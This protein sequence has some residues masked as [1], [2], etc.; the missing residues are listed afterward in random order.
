MQFLEPQLKP[1]STAD[2]IAL[3]DKDFD[4]NIHSREINND[5]EEEV[6]PKAKRK[7]FAKKMEKERS[8]YLKALPMRLQHQKHRKVKHLPLLLCM[9][10][11]NCSKWMLAPVQSPRKGLWTFFSKMK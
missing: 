5:N 9:L 1:E 8:N 6:A 7:S 11:I 2:T 4:K 10:T 3:Q